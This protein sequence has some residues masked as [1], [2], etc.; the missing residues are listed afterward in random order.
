MLLFT[1]VTVSGSHDG[2]GEDFGESQW[3]RE[4][5]DP[6]G[7]GPHTSTDACK[8]GRGRWLVDPEYVCYSFSIRT[9]VSFH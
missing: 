2:D 7:K 9:W 8:A 3:S 1:A 4:S 5:A 6:G